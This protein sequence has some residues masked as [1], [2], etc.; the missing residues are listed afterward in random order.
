MSTHQAS[1]EK[2]TETDDPRERRAKWESFA[3]K[4]PEIGTV[5]VRNHS[6]DDPAAHEYDVSVARSGE[7]TKCSCPSD[8]HQ[9]G[10]CKHRRWVEHHAP[11]AVVIAAAG[12]QTDGGVIDAGDEGKI[13]DEEDCWC[14]G[15]PMP[16]WDCYNTG[17]RDLPE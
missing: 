17:R 16:C 7:T 11:D 8:E 9:S 6:H 1:E 5:T 14:D 3:A 4:V 12:V 2:S 10:P 13:I 15:Q